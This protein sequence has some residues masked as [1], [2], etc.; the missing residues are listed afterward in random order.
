MF[1]L[2]NCLKKCRLIDYNRI[3]LIYSEPGLTFTLRGSWTAKGLS[4]NS[5]G[6]VL[7]VTRSTGG[8]SCTVTN[9]SSSGE[10]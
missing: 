6:S 2:I 9:S 4:P 10:I 7:K 3:S 1:C 5:C 8:T